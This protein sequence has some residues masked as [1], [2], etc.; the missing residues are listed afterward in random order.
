SSDIV[1]SI[2]NKGLEIAIESSNIVGSNFNWNT[3]FNISFVSNKVVE[4]GGEAYK[5][6]GAGDGHLKTGSPHIL[7]VNKPISVFYG[8]VFDGLFNSEQEL[9]EGPEGPTNWLGGRKY[10]DLNGDGVIDATNDRTI[11]GNYH[12]DF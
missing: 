8:Y 5:H 1:D 2:Q 10:R 7:Q 4:L 6:V 12:P 11:I 9:A 3:S